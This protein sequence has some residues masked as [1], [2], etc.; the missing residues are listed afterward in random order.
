MNTLAC[1]LISVG[2]NIFFKNF[3]NSVSCDNDKVPLYVQNMS[4]RDHLDH[5]GYGHL[6]YQRLKM[7][8]KCD[9]SWFYGS[10]LWFYG[11]LLISFFSHTQYD[12]CLRSSQ[13]FGTANHGTAYVHDRIVHGASEEIQASGSA[14]RGSEDAVSANSTSEGENGG[15]TEVNAVPT[16]V[17]SANY[18]ENILLIKSSTPS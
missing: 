12:H 17:R 15:A 10:L 16:H 6:P 8:S 18:V 9:C 11:S 13:R 2:V 14:E 5:F 1:G 3:D 4:S 7:L